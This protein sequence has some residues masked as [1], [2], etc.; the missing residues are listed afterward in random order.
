M[1]EEAGAAP[2]ADTGAAPV[3]TGAP[4]AQ[5]D[6][7]P[8]PQSHEDY[9]NSHKEYLNGYYGANGYPEDYWT[10]SGAPETYE[11]FNYPE[12]LTVDDAQLAELHTFAK[13]NNLSQKQAQ[14]VFDTM[15]EAMQGAHGDGIASVEAEKANQ[16]DQWIEAVKADP[17]LGGDHFDAT[18]RLANAGVQAFGR[19]VPVVD[20]KGQ[21]VMGTDGQPQVYNELADALESTGAGNNPAV[22]RA[23]AMLG[24]LTGEGG[25]VGGKM[26]RT[27][28][29]LGQK[30]YTNS[31]M[32]P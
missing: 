30:L 19:D 1:S 11:A 16:A 9:M 29:S 28:R 10:A 5:A 26:M 22:V 4:A 23:F 17:D 31:R 3:D 20:D 14:N 12:G 6:V 7:A 25:Y 27:D 18:V 8:A 2:A 13:E 32:N 21:P 24:K 15:Y